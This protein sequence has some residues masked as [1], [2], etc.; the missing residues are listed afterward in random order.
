MPG[1]VLDAER[2]AGVALRVEVDH[3]DLQPLQRE[4]GRDVDGGGRL[5]DAALLVRDGEHAL[6]RRPRQSGAGVQ[7]AYGALG[8]RSDRGVT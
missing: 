5:A 3:E 8:F 1:A 6:L 4:R 2:G 7:H